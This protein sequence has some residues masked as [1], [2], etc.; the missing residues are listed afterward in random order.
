MAKGD[1]KKVEQQ[2]ATQGRIG[3]ESQNR[4]I[5]EGIVP[6]QQMFS[7]N[8][9]NAVPQQMEDY[10]N[11]MQ[12]YRDYAGSTKGFEPISAKNVKYSRTPEMAKALAGYGGFADT[13]GFSEGD[14]SNIR[15]RG[16]SP[17]RS[18]YA[19]MQNE[20]L[21]QKNLQGGYSPN[22]G[23]VMTKLGSQASQQI[24]DRTQDIEGQLAEMIQK[25]KLSG[26]SGLGSLASEDIGFG[27]RAQMANQDAALR[28]AGMNMQGSMNDPRLAA[29]NAQASL[30]GATP[31]MAELFGRQVLGN[32]GQW[33]E[34]Q[35]LQNQL[36]Q[37][38]VQG[39]IQASQIP[40]NFE[41]AMKRA[42]T[43]AKI[44]GRIGAGIM[45][46]GASELGIQGFNTARNLMNRGGGGIRA[47]GNSGLLQNVYNQRQNNPM[48]NISFPTG[49]MRF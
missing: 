40:S 48:G 47:G 8:Y 6:S 33:L 11:I 37:Q 31:G 28:A 32:Q 20:L 17:I 5:N 19:N 39:S 9:Q 18:I 34:G 25:G 42:G 7:Q 38:Q 27:Q 36:G 15:A 14:K 30:Y 16:L 29:I 2:V 21:R 3:Q 1:K 24:A 26:L 22:M 13:G 23:A 44:A 43:A 41:T 35:G 49:S 12:Q 45:T 46:G 4:L 10:K